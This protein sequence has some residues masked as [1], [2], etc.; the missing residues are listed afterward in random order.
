MIT[1][2]ALALAAIP[3]FVDT[4]LQ[5]ALAVPGARLEVLA[6]RESGSSGCEATQAEVQRPVTTSGAVVVRLRGPGCESLAWADLRVLAKGLVLTHAVREGEPLQGAAAAAEIE[7]RQGQDLLSSLARDA[8][9][10]RSLPA[11]TQL[12]LHHVRAE[13]PAIGSQVKIEV[14]AGALVAVQ[15]GRVVGCVP[16]RACAI[17]PSGRRVEGTLDAGR[18]LVE[19]P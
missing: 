11:G 14:R 3:A 1:L 6:L 19:A 10:A 8:R 9:A 4:A 7:L 17:L 13:G 12:S 16:G 5:R 2:V 18:I 15:M